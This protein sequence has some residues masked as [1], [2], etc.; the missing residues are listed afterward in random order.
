MRI[1]SGNH[2]GKKIFAP[3]ALPVRPTTDFAKE[4]LFNIINNF[5]YFD[6]IKVLDLFAGTGNISYEF[7][8]RGAISVTSVDNNE[9]CIDF[10][11]KTSE[12]LSF[13]QMDMFKSDVR[14][15]L[16]MHS[17][18]YNVIFADP[19]YDE[20]FDCFPDIIFSRNL[21]LPEGWFILEHGPRKDYSSHPN[22]Y[23]MRNYGKVHFSVFINE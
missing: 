2:R 18:Q 21:L 17:I 7:A 4:A 16:E 15:F 13:T 9:K 23:Q 10:I 11:R 6:S 8:A 3:I 20:P 22:F 14:K 1:I 19:P 5:F 12:Q